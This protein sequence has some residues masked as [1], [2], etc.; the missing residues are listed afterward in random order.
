[1]KDPKA[2]QIRRTEQFAFIIKNKIFSVCSVIALDKGHSVI[3]AVDINMLISTAFTVI[4]AVAA[5]WK[6]NSFMSAAIEADK[7]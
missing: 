5:W 7:K 6:N 3:N 2:K 1:M 4:T